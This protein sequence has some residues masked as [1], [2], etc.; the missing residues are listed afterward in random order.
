MFDTKTFVFLLYE[1]FMVFNFPLASDKWDF[2]QSNI[3][4]SKKIILC[5]RFTLNGQLS[6]IATHLMT[7]RL[8]IYWIVLVLWCEVVSQNLNIS[9]YDWRPVHFINF[10]IVSS[11]CLYTF[12]TY[13][14]DTNTL[15]KN[16][17][18]FIKQGSSLHCQYVHF[19][20]LQWL[21]SL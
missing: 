6:L 21:L 13:L 16:G 14:E 17:I 20:D 18:S 3:K 1:H 12:D 10:K 9:S 2:Q 8:R 11:K 15:L 5:S 4:P 19:G 7:R